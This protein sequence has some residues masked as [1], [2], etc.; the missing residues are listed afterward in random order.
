MTI[1]LW[2]EWRCGCYNKRNSFY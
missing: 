2:R 1:Y